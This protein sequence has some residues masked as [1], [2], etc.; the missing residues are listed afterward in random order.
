MVGQRINL[1]TDAPVPPSR[2]DVRVSLPYNSR[3]RRDEVVRTKVAFLC[4]LT[5]SGFVLSC[6]LPPKLRD[7][8][9]LPNAVKDQYGNPVVVRDGKKFDPQTGLPYEIWLKEPRIEFVLIPAGNFLMGSPKGEKGRFYNEGPRH[10]IRITKPFYL[11]KYE[12]T[13]KQWK[14]VMG[15]EPWAGKF[16][17]NNHPTSPANYISWED[18]A[19]FIKELSRRTGLR[20]SLPSEGEWEYAC[21]AGNQTAFYYGDDP[22]KLADYAWYY[23]NCKKSAEMYPHIVGRKKPNNWGLYDMLGN[24]WE[25]C[26]DYFKEEYYLRSPTDDPEGPHQGSY[27]VLRGGAWFLDASLCRCATRQGRLPS[28]LSTNLGFRLALHELTR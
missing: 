18:C 25:W 22:S 21:R 19:G 14:S 3:R 24:V 13:Q 11:A 20:F 8:F 2:I 1:L 7:A 9:M 6:Q 12:V 16:G 15:N 28:A 17:V 10:K 26:H 23:D 4:I 27:R 5:L